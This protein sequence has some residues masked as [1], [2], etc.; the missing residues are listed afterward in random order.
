MG[1]VGLFLQLVEAK[2]SVEIYLG[3]LFLLKMLLKSFGGV[4]GG[5]F[6]K[7]VLLCDVI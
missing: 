1:Q 4:L 7:Y 6:E 3:L 5:R 2:F